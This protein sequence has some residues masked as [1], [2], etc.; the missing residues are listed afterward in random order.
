M[1]GLPNSAVVGT[2][3][4]LK[5]VAKKSA[6]KRSP[7]VVVRTTKTITTKKATIHRELTVTE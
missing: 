6:H 7:R 2:T 1:W 5:R 4:R 3:K